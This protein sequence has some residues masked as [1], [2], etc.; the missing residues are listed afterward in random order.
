MLRGLLLLAALLWLAGSS[1]RA[2]PFTPLHDD[3]VLEELPSSLLG[4]TR[5]LRAALAREPGNVER[6]AALATHYIELGRAE[7]DPRYFGWAEGAIAPWLALA[8]P[9]TAVLM[10]RATLRQSRH[11]FAAA[12]QDLA[13]VLARDPR[14]AEA[15]LTASAVLLVQGAAAAAERACLPLLRLGEPL[16]ATV[17]LADAGSMRGQGERSL[18]LLEGALRN[19]EDAPPALR[20]FALTSLAELAARLGHDERAEQAFEDALALGRRDA[21][22]LAARGDYL[23]DRGR[24]AEVV[25]LLADET[26]ADGLLLRLVLAEQQLGAEPL[27]EHAAMLRARFR[28]GRARGLSVHQGEEA[29]FALRIE[30]DAAAALALAKG[31]FA[32]QR[33]PRDARVLLEAALAAEDRAAAC[34][35]LDWIAANHVEDVRLA[36]LAARLEETR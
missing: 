7:S 2:V 34:P 4:P 13:R 35:A 3:E 26:R 27:A 11:E 8:E 5:E 24:P 19:T 1:A 12:Q 28:A 32:L 18:A 31:N 22:L 21:Y 9:P 6:A 15:W 25:S 14:N 23:L 36:A 30:G 10:L 16:A 20:L 33:E 17:C 29:R